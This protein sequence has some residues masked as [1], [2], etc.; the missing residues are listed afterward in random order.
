MFPTIEKST[1]IERLFKS[2]LYKVFNFLREGILQIHTFPRL[3]AE[4]DAA[5]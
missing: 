1:Q 5:Y 3:F 2:Q 4:T